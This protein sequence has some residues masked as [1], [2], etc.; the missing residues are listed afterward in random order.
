V[1]QAAEKMFFSKTAVGVVLILH[2]SAMYAQIDE[3]EAVEVTPTVVSAETDSLGYLMDHEAVPNWYDFMGNLPH[4]YG[5]FVGVSANLKSI[6]A[7][8]G[9]SVLTLG[10]IASDR[11]TYKYSSGFYERS[12]A[13]ASVSDFF[14]SLG[15]GKSPLILAGAFGVY[16]FAASDRRAIRTASQTLEALLATGLFVQTLKRISGRESPSVATS[17]LGTWRPF[18]SFKEYHTHQSKYH[19]FPSG[20]IATTMATVTVIAENY[21]EQ[22]WLRPVGYSIVGL[23]GIS[24]VNNGWH[25]YSDLPLG[26]ALGYVFGKIVTHPNASSEASPNETQLTLA[27]VINEYGSGVHISLHF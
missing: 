17:E 20:H 25:W 7:I 22:E 1:E 9:L 10:L 24:L 16:G 5:A 18:P 8:V 6:P 3:V 4:D 12:D 13:V 15:D 26:I 14:V 19:A 2:A 11:E 21:P 23:V 27:P